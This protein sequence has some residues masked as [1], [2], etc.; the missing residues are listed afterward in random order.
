MVDAGFNPR[1]SLDRAPALLAEGWAVTL[2]QAVALAL[3][4][5]DPD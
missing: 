3:D 1:P 5:T 4:E 2:E